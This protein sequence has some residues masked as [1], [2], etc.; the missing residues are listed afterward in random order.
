MASA[1]DSVVVGRILGPWGI[2]GWVQ[3]YS[4]TEPRDQIFT[5]TPWLIGPNHQRIAPLAHKQ[6]GKRLVVQLPDVETPE[7]AQRWVDQDIRILYDQLP[8]LPEG[9][10]Y[11]CD[12]IGLKV[13]NREQQS[14]GTIREV[15]AT[16]AHD[17]IVLEPAEQ[18]T[19]ILI[20]FVQGVFIDEVN[21]ETGMVHV[22]W[23]SEWLD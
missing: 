15:L 8:A 20:P 11:W 9:E 16:G 21:L 4:Y 3:I 12:L 10:Y 14:L 17:V 19:P 6:S 23:P 1:Q 13:I 18:A 5:Y 7:Q 22:D 2:Q